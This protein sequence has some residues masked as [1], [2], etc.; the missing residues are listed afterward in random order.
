MGDNDLQDVAEEVY[1][2][3]TISNHGE[4]RE[5]RICRIPRAPRLPRGYILD[6]FV[7]YSGY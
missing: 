3:L 6:C 2:E 5:E 4:H 1:E 7:L